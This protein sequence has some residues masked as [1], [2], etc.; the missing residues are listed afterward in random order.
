MLLGKFALG[1]NVLRTMLRMLAGQDK[2]ASAASGRCSGCL[3]AKTRQH[4]Q[5]QDDAQD[6]CWPRP[7]SILS[8]PR[9]HSYIGV[10]MERPERSSMVNSI[11]FL[12]PNTSYTGD[13]ILSRAP[14]SFDIGLNSLT[15]PPNH[16]P[17]LGELRF[18]TL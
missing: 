11:V 8:L 18:V 10:G 5:H 3:L 14:Y 4:Q 6:A 7:G 1:A 15:T 17:W 13:H 9:I 12:H 16:I 2:A